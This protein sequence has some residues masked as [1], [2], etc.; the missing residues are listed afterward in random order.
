MNNRIPHYTRDEEGILVFDI[1]TRRIFK[2]LM[3]K[4][5]EAEVD[6]EDIRHKL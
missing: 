6:A 1:D 4:L 2:R 3:N 5:C